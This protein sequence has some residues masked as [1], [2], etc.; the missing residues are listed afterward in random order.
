MRL[1]KLILLLLWRPL[2]TLYI[3]Y[4]A[5]D[6]FGWIPYALAGALWLVGFVRPGISGEV[7]ALMQKLSAWIGGGGVAL[8]FLAGLDAMWRRNSTLL[9][10]QKGI[11]DRRGWLE[12]I[13]G[14][15]GLCHEADYP[16]NGLCTVETVR[17]GVKSRATEQSINGVQVKL[18]QLLDG[19]EAGKLLP[20]PLSLKDFPGYARVRTG[21]AEHYYRTNGRWHPVHQPLA[22]V[23][24]TLAEVKLA[25]GEVAY[26]DIAFYRYATA[27]TVNLAYASPGHVSVL[28]MP[29][30]KALQL[31]VVGDG[32]PERRYW[33]KLEVDP[34]T[35]KG[36]TCLRL[37][38]TDDEAA[39]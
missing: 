9:A 17:V 15:A 24:E 21:L 36:N 13:H 39:E 31:S 29:V 25:P 1:A 32:V 38:R 22:V 18:W 4:R 34:S 2:H 14:E 7:A 35:T 23:P 11:A 30:K 8:A 19:G 37:R 27:N 28:P 16:G 26:F 12:L 3:G 10:E 6:A 20:Q 5:L 33:F